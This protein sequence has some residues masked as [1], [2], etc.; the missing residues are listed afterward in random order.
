M[1]QPQA[2]EIG[3]NAKV[4]ARTRKELWWLANSVS[5]TAQKGVT[6]QSNESFC[7]DRRRDAVSPK[8][9]G[10]M[11]SQTIRAS[12]FGELPLAHDADEQR[13]E[14]RSLEMPSAGEL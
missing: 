11:P 9:I 7:R 14:L 8:A 2:G 3:A 13:H 10:G 6:I 4:R 12:P 1:R 5:R